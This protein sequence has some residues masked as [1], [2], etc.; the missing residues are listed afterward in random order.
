M[1]NLQT[2]ENEI[3]KAL[4]ELKNAN[5]GSLVEINNMEFIIVDKFGSVRIEGQGFTK[6]RN[7]NEFDSYTIIGQ[8]IQLIHVLKWHSLFYSKYSHFEVHNGESYFCV[9][10]GEETESIVWNLNENLLKNQSKELIDFLFNLA[11]PNFD[12]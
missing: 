5:T 7:L 11:G 4:P 12:Q 3:R 1:T 6:Y 2:L 10:D 9:Y 8:E